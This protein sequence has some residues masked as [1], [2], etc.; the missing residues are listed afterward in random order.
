MNQFKILFLCISMSLAGCASV[1]QYQAGCEELNPLFP[2]MVVC[3]KE[4]LNTDRRAQTS[5]NQPY[6]QRYLLEA[7]KLA[8]MV[9]DKKISEIDARIR[10][11]DLYMH[12]RNG[13]NAEAQVTADSWQRQQVINNMN[14]PVNT[15]CYG[16]GNGVHC[17]SY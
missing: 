15:N 16:T 6:V 7:D 10:L 9:Q 14:K 1:S 11:S 5:G 12:L 8:H 3:L 17:Q 13:Q 2:D 4:K